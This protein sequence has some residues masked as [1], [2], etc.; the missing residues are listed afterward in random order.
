MERGAA[1]VRR[2]VG[3]RVYRDDG[4]FRDQSAALIVDPAPAALLFELVVVFAVTVTFVS[5][6][7]DDASFVIPPP[8]NPG[9]IV[10]DGA[11]V[12]RDCLTGAA[13]AAA[14]AA[15]R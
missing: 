6:M 8:E 9:L 4:V 11:V 2:S 7:V 15:T 1:D 14:Q 13:A 10:S 5:V 3:L 12:Q